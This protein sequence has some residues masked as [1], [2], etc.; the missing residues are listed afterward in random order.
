META[1]TKHT[2]NLYLQF[3]VLVLTWFFTSIK[4]VIEKEKIVVTAEKGED[5]I[6]RPE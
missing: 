2:Q 3:A 5:I 1:A 4:S 6:L